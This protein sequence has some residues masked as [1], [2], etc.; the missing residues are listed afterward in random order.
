MYQVYSIYVV[1]TKYSIFYFYVY[2]LKY[3]S[4][5]KCI[6]IFIFNFFGLFSVS[7][8]FRGHFFRD[9]P[10]HGF[11]SNTPLVDRRVDGNSYIY[12]VD[13]SLA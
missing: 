1:C 13:T 10:S 7:F 12:S 9:S 4:I 11:N 5:N 8:I 2:Y 3:V 6:K